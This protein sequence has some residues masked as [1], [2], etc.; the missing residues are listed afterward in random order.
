MDI[1]ELFVKV[2]LGSPTRKQ[3]TLNTSNLNAGRLAKEL[4]K[5]TRFLREKEKENGVR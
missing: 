1:R 3:R 5:R 2:G 4:A